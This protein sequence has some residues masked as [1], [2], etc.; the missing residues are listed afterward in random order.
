VVA[1]NPYAF[2]KLN[3]TSD[4]SVGSVVAYDPV[5]GPN[6]TY[7]TAAQNG[8]NGIVGPESPAFPGFPAV[9][10]ALG[11]ASNAANSYVTASAG[12]M[13][14]TNLTYAM[15][16]NPS[17]PVENW[18]GL[19]MDRGAAGEGLGF[20]GSINA[21]GMSELA[22]TWNANS[23]WSYNSYLYPPA[24]QW[25]FVALV[26][27]PT[28]AELYLINSSGVQTA[29][30]VL[31]HDS[32]EF[33]VAWH[34][35]DDAAGGTAGQRT[36]PGSIADVSVY[37]SALSSYQI[38]GLYDAGVGIVQG[39]VV[40]TLTPAGAGTATLNWSQGTLLQSTNLTGPWTP[41]TTTSPY[42]VGTSNAQSFFKVQ[43][44]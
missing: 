16:I 9:N 10:W 21:A 35:G 42:T 6:G 30:N 31:A 15:W 2:W 12:S 44:Q 7:Q 11:T 24:N 28:Q 5:G 36:F 1:G 19:L 38:S 34:I 22:Y 13:I 29:T 23:T 39:P 26:I 27:Q 33:G 8:F 18:A 14:A 32:E 37:L 4:P 25:S 41:V 40:L 17:G 43:V 20:G 3:E